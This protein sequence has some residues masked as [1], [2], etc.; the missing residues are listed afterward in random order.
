MI[1]MLGI[2]MF[3]IQDY[4]D[5]RMNGISG[6]VKVCPTGNEAPQ[7]HSVIVLKT[8]GPCNP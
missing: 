1:A 3:P 4:E 8:G 7:L 6:A 2:A 5:G